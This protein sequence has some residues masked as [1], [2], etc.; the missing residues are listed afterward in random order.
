MI[1]WSLS[2][3]LIDL[4]SELYIKGAK[5]SELMMMMMMMMMIMGWNKSDHN[6]INERT[7]TTKH[8]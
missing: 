7:V 3:N 8:I 2:F 6:T 1:T 4:I 5:V